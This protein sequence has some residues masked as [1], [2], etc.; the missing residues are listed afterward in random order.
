VEGDDKPGRLSF[1]A[2]SAAVSGYLERNPYALS[3]E[4]AK[5]LFVP[6]TI[7]PWVLE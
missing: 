5:G 1:K 6:K 3:C 7:I 2:L 4:I